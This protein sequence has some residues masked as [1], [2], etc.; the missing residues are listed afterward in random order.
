M[1]LKQLLDFNSTK[2][3]RLLVLNAINEINC[4]G[5]GCDCSDYLLKTRGRPIILEYTGDGVIKMKMCAFCTVLNVSHLLGTIKDFRFTQFYT[6][7]NKAAA[8]YLVRS[9]ASDFKGE[10]F[11]VVVIP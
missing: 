11:Q 8:L 5:C 9:F 2:E 3:E 1:S 10:N 6:P 4:P 7:I